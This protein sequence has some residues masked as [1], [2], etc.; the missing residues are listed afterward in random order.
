MSEAK[1]LAQQSGTFAVACNLEMF[2]TCARLREQD[3]KVVEGL[4]VEREGIEG[5]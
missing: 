3:I 1:I 5:E 4:H 2:A